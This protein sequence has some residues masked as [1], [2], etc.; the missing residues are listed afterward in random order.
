MA[1][2]TLQLESKHLYGNTTVSVILPDRPFME[3]PQ[4]LYSKKKNII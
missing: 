3:D 2:V 4:K 1:L